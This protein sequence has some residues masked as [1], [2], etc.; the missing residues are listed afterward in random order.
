MPPAPSDMAPL[1]RAHTIL[2][3]RSDVDPPYSVSRARVERCFCSC[4]EEKCGLQSCER[5][6]ISVSVC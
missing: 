5:L 4:S 1:G 3:T 6:A 2:G